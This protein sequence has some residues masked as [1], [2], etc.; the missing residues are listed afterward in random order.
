MKL[1]KDNDPARLAGK[2][3]HP[4]VTDMVLHTLTRDGKSI[5][6]PATCNREVVPGIVYR[7]IRSWHRGTYAGE[8]LEQ[9]HGD[10]SGCIKSVNVSNPPVNTRG[11]ITTLSM[12]M[13]MTTQ[14]KTTDH[15]LYWHV[16]FPDDTISAFL[17][18]P[19]GMGMCDSYFWEAYPMSD[20][21]ER[22]SGDAAEIEMEEA[23]IAELQRRTELK[24]GTPHA[25]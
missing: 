25:S 11:A 17:S 24:R 4:N 16:D 13:N 19:N 15:R 10:A 18:Y 20:G 1:P 3:K 14:P 23:V 2:L 7:A 22:W 21:E 12:D 6:L 8:G 5:F 9:V